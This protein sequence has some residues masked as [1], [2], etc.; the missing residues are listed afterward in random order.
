M[1]WTIPEEPHHGRVG[2]TLT[3]TGLPRLVHRHSELAAAVLLGVAKVVVGF[4]RARR[5]GAPAGEEDAND[6]GGAS[7]SQR[8][9]GEENRRCGFM[10]RGGARCRIVRG[11][12]EIEGK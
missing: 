7:R 5:Q 12:I 3:T 8:R 6:A 9:A 2:V 4:A 11:S 1:L 10:K